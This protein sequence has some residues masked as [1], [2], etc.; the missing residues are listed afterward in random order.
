MFKVQKRMCSTCIYRPDTP[1]DLESLE[2]AVRDPYG[3]FSGWRACHHA[4]GDVCCRGFYEAHGPD[5]NVIRVAG[6]L[7]VIQF[8]EVD[9]LT[10]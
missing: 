9:T 1:L 2:D 7:G 10:K 4:N 5:C 6:R 8:V 3:G